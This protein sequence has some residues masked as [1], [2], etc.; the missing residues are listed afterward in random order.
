MCVCVCV[1]EREKGSVRS[2]EESHSWQCDLK[3]DCGTINLGSTDH[4]GVVQT[5]RVVLKPGPQVPPVLPVLDVSLLQTHLIQ[6]NGSL[7][8][9]VEAW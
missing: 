9:S 8:S 2:G 6:I 5:R 4:G 7:S 1:R 3:A